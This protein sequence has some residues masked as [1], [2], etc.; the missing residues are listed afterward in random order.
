MI[1]EINKIEMSLNVLRSQVARIDSMIEDNENVRILLRSSEGVTFQQG[2]MPFKSMYPRPNIGQQYSPGGMPYQQYSPGGMPYQQPNSGQQYSLSLYQKV[3]EYSLKL[4]ES[5]VRICQLMDQL[6]DRL[7]DIISRKPGVSTFYGVPD[8]NKRCKQSCPIF[9]DTGSMIGNPNYPKKDKV[10][11]N[12]KAVSPAWT[13]KLGENPA[14]MHL[15]ADFKQWNIVDDASWAAAYN[16]AINGQLPADFDWWGL[17]NDTG[18]TMAHVAAVNGYLPA[19]FNQWG[20]DNKSGTTVAHEAAANGHLPADFDQWEL[21][22]KAGYTV[23]HV[24]AANGHLPTDFNK[25]ELADSSGTTVAHVAA[26]NG[27]LPA[28]FDQWEL[29]DDDGWTV[30]HTAAVSNH[31]PANFK[32]WELADISGTTVADTAASSGCLI[33]F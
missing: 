11:L 17:A 12:K 16:A 9:E 27:Y 29:A 19:D 26:S 1:E 18:Y 13:T 28:S 22:N 32:Q 8:E 10:D 3:E 15:P 25:W 6:L 21:A 20:L 23:A 30:A 24:A 33:K 2:G 14:S 4:I 7:N 31:L 5:K